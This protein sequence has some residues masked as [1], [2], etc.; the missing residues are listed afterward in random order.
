MKSFAL[1][2]LAFCFMFQIAA[3]DEPTT[4][5]ESKKMPELVMVFTKTEGWRH[6][7][8]EKG[9]Q[10]L[11]ELG[12]KNGFIPLQTESGEDFTPQN[13]NNYKLVVFLNTTLDVLNNAQQKAFEGYI[14]GGGSFLGI[15][16]A[17]DTEYDWP[18]YGKLVGGYFDSHPND[19][20]VRKA[21]I[22]VV[23]KAHPAT[24]HLQDSWIRTDEWY[25]YKNLSSDTT[26]LLKLDENS[27]EGG[28]N[29]SNHPIA[30]YH[31]FD[32]G[33][34]FYTGGGHTEDSYDEPMFRQHLL[35]AI[36]W[37]LKR[38]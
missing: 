27:Y 12:R 1:S 22:D 15:H 28:T 16:S 18:W 24:E 35:G 5:A 30:W 19:P 29:G 34:A 20:N 3:Q 2:L 10:T 31:E 14:Q 33:R 7:S 32:G 4:E 9:V 36:E 21:T 6:K 37:C 25:N 26:V 13:L 23:S 8:I 38:K 11:R 17:C